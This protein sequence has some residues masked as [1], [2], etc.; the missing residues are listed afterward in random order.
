LANNYGNLVSRVLTMCHKYTE[1]KVPPVDVENLKADSRSVIA[2]AWKQYDKD[3]L[4]NINI[5]AA[6]QSPIKLLDYANRRIEE[7]KPWEMAKSKSQKAELD[8]LLYELLELI[9]AVTAMMWPAIPGTAQKVAIE[10][11]HSLPGEVW[12]DAKQVRQW[13]RLRSDDQLGPLPF[14]LFP[15]QDG[16]K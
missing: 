10:L 1:G 8:T 6:L 12:N 15:R 14:I 3:L 4:E 7:S 5:Q 13:A 11:F 2:A 16:K 9:R